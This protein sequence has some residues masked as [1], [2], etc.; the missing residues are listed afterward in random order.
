M[1]QPQLTGKVPVRSDRMSADAH[2]YGCQGLG[3]W[4]SHSTAAASRG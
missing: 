2:G 1:A 3:I 4:L